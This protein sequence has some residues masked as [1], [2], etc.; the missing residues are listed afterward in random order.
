MWLKLI[1]LLP[2]QAICL[3]QSAVEDVIVLEYMQQ[4]YD[5]MNTHPNNSLTSMYSEMEKNP[6]C[7]TCRNIPPDSEYRVAT[8]TSNVIVHS[9]NIN[10]FVSIHSG[11]TLPEEE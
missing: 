9:G 3:T 1:G 8:D 2:T 7:S 11:V 10:Q 4:I 6:T 5:K